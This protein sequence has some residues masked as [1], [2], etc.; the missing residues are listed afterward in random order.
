MRGKSPFCVYY[1]LLDDVNLAGTVNST[2]SG[3]QFQWS[4]ADGTVSFGIFTRGAVSDFKPYSDQLRFKANAIVLTRELSN[5]AGELRG[6]VQRAEQWISN[7]EL[8]EQRIPKAKQYYRT[9]EDR[10]RSLV[11]RERGTPDPIG[12]SEISY[13]V[14]E[15]DY[16]GDQIDF[17]IEQLWDQEIGDGGRNLKDEFAKFP[18]ACGGTDEFTKRGADLPTVETW[19]AACQQASDEREKFDPI[20]KRIMEQRAD[21]KS[22]RDSARAQRKALVQEA[23]KLQQRQ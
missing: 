3:I 4:G 2:E 13:K 8:H 19:K 18:S 23:F 1:G 5:H 15:G 11:Q 7:A 16:A 6:A 22:V 20:F 12:R 14:N 9:I 10:M 21:L 17:Q